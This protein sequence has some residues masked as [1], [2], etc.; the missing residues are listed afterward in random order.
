MSGLE[1]FSA[2]SLSRLLD[3]HWGLPEAEITAHEGGM[4]SLTWVVRHGGERR[5][6]KA[7]SAER[8]GRRFAAGLAAASRLTEAGI[9]AGAPVPASDGALTVEYDGTAL[10]LLSWV[11]GDAV[12]QN[13]TEGMRLI[14]NTLARAH[15][16]LG[17]SPGK[18]D[19]EP[20]H[21][22]SRLYLGV[23]P[24]IRPAIASA[25]AAVEALDPETLT[26]GPLHG[27]PAAEAFLRDPASGEVGL[28]DWGA[29]TVGPRVFDLASAVMYAG[30]LDRARPLI[31]AY[32]DAGALSGAEVDRALPAMLG[33]R[34][35]SQAYYFA[36]RI[37]ADDRTGIA[38]PAEN[39]R[40][41]ADAKAY[42]APP[43]IRAYEA[44]DENEWVRCRAVAFLDTSYYDAVEPV[45]PTVEADEVID[46]VAVDD[47]HIVGI[48]DIA[49]RG[50]LATIETLC[51]HPEYRRLAIATRLLWE[52]I[53]RLE[54][55]PAR[56]LDA[57][58][59]EDRAALEWYAARGF[60][61]AES[62]LH[63][64]SGL[65]A[66]NT[67]RMTEFRAPYRPILI[68]AAAPREHET[69]ARA[70]F[71]RVYVCRR[72]LRQLA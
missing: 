67:A 34:W 45:K 17:S 20:R 41:L 64:Y 60:V 35:A 47:G 43:E 56:I 37:A 44:A 25:H 63:V 9:P 12:E 50:D 71:Q 65:G 19:I 57:W 42:L 2:R 62:F 15:L 40:G 22:P 21:D 70:E 51:V 38:D 16:A 33:W 49:V 24:W 13:T 72:L 30:N 6:A 39:E 69:K 28:I 68:F 54:H 53:A 55:T 23:R 4:S 36:Y 58:T 3:E 31:E 59:R 5:L 7:V 29:Y 52:G 46:L 18:P 26:W 1:S 27:D 10:A 61:E 48:L 8:Y 11:D 14:G 66:E 32:I